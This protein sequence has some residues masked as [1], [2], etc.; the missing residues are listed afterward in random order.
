MAAAQLKVRIYYIINL[1]QKL[2]ELINI[3]NLCNFQLFASNIEENI[4]Q[5]LKTV[6]LLLK[7]KV[8]EP[9][10]KEP[11]TQNL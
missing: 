3:S 4:I 2:K 10:I 7:K 8:N 6:K 1:I 5:S 11:S 9:Y